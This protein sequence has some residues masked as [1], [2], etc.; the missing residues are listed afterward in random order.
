MHNHGFCRTRSIETL[1]RKLCGGRTTAAW[2]GGPLA[3]P[4][5]IPPACGSSRALSPWRSQRTVSPVHHSRETSALPAAIDLGGVP[6]PKTPDNSIEAMSWRPTLR[7]LDAVRG[8]RAPEPTSKGR[9]C[10]CAILTNRA[11][12]GCAPARR[13]WTRCGAARQA[14]RPG[15]AHQRESPGVRLAGRSRRR[16]AELCAPGALRHPAPVFVRAGCLKAPRI[17]TA[18]DGGSEG[19]A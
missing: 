9:S 8:C 4:R 17:A 14:E 10:P 1:T 12:V 11:P 19:K 5:C 6:A 7:G 15:Q 2:Q 18:S 3:R 16:F 13:R